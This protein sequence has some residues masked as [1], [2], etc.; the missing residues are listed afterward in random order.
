[1]KVLGAQNQG[2]PQHVKLIITRVCVCVCVCV[3]VVETLWMR[4]WGT[5]LM[6]WFGV[7]DRQK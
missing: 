5:D 7:T 4:G 6:S 1:M 3:H 2:Q